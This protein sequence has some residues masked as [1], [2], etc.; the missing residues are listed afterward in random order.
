VTV[1]LLKGPVAKE[2]GGE[3]VA[4]HVS[5]SDAKSTMY[6]KSPSA[7]LCIFAARRTRQRC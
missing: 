7:G 3:D 2:G 6:R 1:L 5:D 4:V